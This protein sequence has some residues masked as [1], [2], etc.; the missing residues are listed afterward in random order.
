MA[1]DLQSRLGRLDGVEEVTV[2]AASGSLVIRYRQ[3]I[4]QPELLLAATVRL[5]GLEKELEKTPRPAV[6]RELRSMFDSLNHVVYDRTG[7]LLDFS[8]A[9]LILLAALGANKLLQQGS[10]AMPAGFTLI[11]WGVHRLLGCGGEE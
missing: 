8:S 3:K 2:S 1:Q 5:L 9:V 11:W 6:V 4:V 10:A 7:G